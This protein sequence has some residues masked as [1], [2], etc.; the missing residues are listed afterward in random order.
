MLITNTP[1]NELH[2]YNNKGEEIVT[3]DDKGVVKPDVS[4]G[5]GSG[6]DVHYPIKTDGSLRFAFYRIGEY[7]TD[8]YGSI[9]VSQED[10][11]AYNEWVKNISPASYFVTE[12]E[13]NIVGSTQHHRQI[14]RLYETN[15]YSGE[16]SDEWRLDNI[17]ILTTGS[18]SLYYE[19][20]DDEP[21]VMYIGC[22]YYD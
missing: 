12:Y 20:F 14:S 17:S 18:P 6:A 11:V 16:Y 7:T 22:N 15:Y 2:V 13:T 8:D 5:G 19:G 10:L 21:N 4:G 9:I 3:L 1:N